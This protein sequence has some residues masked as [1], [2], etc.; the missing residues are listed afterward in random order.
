MGILESSEREPFHPQTPSAHRQPQ[1]NSGQPKQVW[2]VILKITEGVK[3]I[4][5]PEGWPDCHC[6]APPRVL[7]LQPRTMDDDHL[8]VV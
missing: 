8:I 4:L 2:Q 7:S 3:T 1:I 6:R 5:W